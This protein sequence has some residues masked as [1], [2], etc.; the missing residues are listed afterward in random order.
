LVAV[1]S[2][3]FE[4]VEAAARGGVPHDLRA[5]VVTEEPRNGA[6]N[7]IGPSGVGAV[8]AGGSG[9]GIGKRG[10]L[11][12][13]LIEGRAICSGSASACRRDREVPVDRFVVEQPG[14]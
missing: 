9:A 3:R 6:L 14:E 7:T 13:L 10:H 11:D 2:L 1:R 12:G 4:A 8:D 5:V